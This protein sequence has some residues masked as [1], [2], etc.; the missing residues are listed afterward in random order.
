MPDSDWETDQTLFASLPGGQSVIDWFGFCPS[1]HDARLAR[2]E[3]GTNVGLMTIEAFRTTDKVDQNGYYVMDRH[4]LVTLRM[5]GVSGVKLEGNAESIIS[6]LV[7]R[8]LSVDPAASDWTSCVG[9]TKGDIE[10]A[11]DTSVGLYGTLYSQDLEFEIR[12]I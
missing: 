11:F 3:L 10:I 6:R 1:F 9:P 7:I 8:R 5:N 2:L 12:S 4:A